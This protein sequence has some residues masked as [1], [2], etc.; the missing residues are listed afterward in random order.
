MKNYLVTESEHGVWQ[1]QEKLH[2]AVTSAQSESNVNAL[3][4]ITTPNKECIKT[5]ETTK[6]KEHYKTSESPLIVEENTAIKVTS[7]PQLEK[8]SQEIKQNR[9]LTVSTQEASSTSTQIK[10]T[11]DVSDAKRASLSRDD[12]ELVT[13]MDVQAFGK[14]GK[15]DQKS[16]PTCS[17]DVHNEENKVL[18]VQEVVVEQTRVPRKEDQKIKTR[19]AKA[20][21]SKPPSTPIE[22]SQQRIE[23]ETKELLE[24]NLKEDTAVV[25]PIVS[26]TSQEITDIPQE[27]LL[28]F[29]LDKDT[30]VS[31]TSSVKSETGV[32]SVV[33]QDQALSNLSNLPTNVSPKEGK[34]VISL[35]ESDKQVAAN[36]KIEVNQKEKKI[37]KKLKKKSA[38]IT[39]EESAAVS[40]SEK[41]TS[42][43]DNMQDKPS[44][45]SVAPHVNTPHEVTSVQL[46]VLIYINSYIGSE[47]SL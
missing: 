28:T 24:A 19:H 26:E 44:I 4:T 29:S 31:A 25:S 8:I 5:S 42:F 39:S 2:C 41:V 16:I 9:S 11:F 12:Q 21:L 45:A 10:E 14:V 30:K 3:E 36:E 32:F 35:S 43:D 7:E 18:S 22:I 1:K 38:R 17:A 13:V 37:E 47:T 40:K 46:Q 27:S 33:S 6:I 23:T 34:A 20:L 15:I